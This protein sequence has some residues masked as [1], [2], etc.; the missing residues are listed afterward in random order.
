ML[1]F[2]ISVLM[3]FCINQSVY[4]DNIVDTV[5][6]NIISDTNFLQ[7][8]S[9]TGEDVKEVLE[10]EHL[11]RYINFELESQQG[12]VNAN[13]DIIQWHIDKIKNFLSYIF[14]PNNH[15]INW[16][17]PQNNWNQPQV[18]QNNWNQPQQPPNTNWNQQHR[19]RPP[20]THN[21]CECECDSCINCSYKNSQ[22][23]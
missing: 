2:F 19:R 7:S 13:W 14:T 21:Y 5:K 17:Q 11:Q 8:I 1:N 22:N 10:D 4:A 12:E 15:H 18:P 6:Q 20:R 9:A 3:F 16:N 23:N